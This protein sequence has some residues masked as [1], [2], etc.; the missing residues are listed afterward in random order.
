MREDCA[1]SFEE[2]C[3]AVNVAKRVK[4]GEERV[5]NFEESMEDLER[6][7]RA[8]ASQKVQEEIDALKRMKI[9][10]ETM[11]LKRLTTAPPLGPLL[12]AARGAGP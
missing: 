9:A 6:D 1:F 11:A 8:D 10:R 12:G 3:L 5:F 4:R 2:T 7:R